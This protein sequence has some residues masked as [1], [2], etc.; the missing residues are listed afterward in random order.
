MTVLDIIRACKRIRIAPGQE[1]ITTFRTP[2]DAYR[3]L[4][5]PFDPT[6]GPATLRFGNWV[7]RNRLARTAEIYV[8]DIIIHSKDEGDHGDHVREVLQDLRENELSG[9]VGTCLLVRVRVLLRLT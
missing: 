7:L 3:S 5:L 1:D 8:D 6:G 9:H 4:V 2:L